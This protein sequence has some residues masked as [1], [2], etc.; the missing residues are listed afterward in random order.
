MTAAYHAEPRRSTKTAWRAVAGLTLL[1]SEKD[2]R[3]HRKHRELEVEERTGEQRFTA[4]LREHSEEPANQTKP[5]EAFRQQ[6]VRKFPQHYFSPPFAC[7]WWPRLWS[8]ERSTDVQRLF[9]KTIGVSPFIIVPRHDF[10]QVTVDHVCQ[11]QVNDGGVG[12]HFEV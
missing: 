11:G 6:L 12:V 10:D 9:N 5:V 1:V 8:A 7:G 3:E 4:H 2:P